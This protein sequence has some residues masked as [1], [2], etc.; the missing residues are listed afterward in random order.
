MFHRT[1]HSIPFPHKDVSQSNEFV[2]GHFRQ[3]RHMNLAG[4]GVDLEGGRFWRSR[5]RTE[6]TGKKF[7]L[8]LRQWIGCVSQRVSNAP[9]RNSFFEPSTHFGH[10]ILPELI[11][12]IMSFFALF[13]SSDRRNGRRKH[14]L[15]S[16]L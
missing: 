2:E 3:I 4:K 5:R 1:I 12:Y 15:F 6:S 8:G 9:A 7:P 10:H 13:S 11:H 14:F 16:R